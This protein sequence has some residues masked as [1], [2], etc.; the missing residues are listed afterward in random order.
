MRLTV[1]RDGGARRY[2]GGYYTNDA[3]IG[4]LNHLAA[5]FE[6]LDYIA[7]ITDMDDPSEVA[8][9]N[10]GKPVYL[11]QNINTY[12]T[13]QYWTVTNYY[14]HII[15][16]LRINWPVFRDRLKRGET[17]AVIMIIPSNNWLMVY[18]LARLRGIPIFPYFIGNQESIVRESGKYSGAVRSLAILLSKVHGFFFRLMARGADGVF[19]LGSELA[20]MFPAR[21][22]RSYQT[23]TSLVTEDDIQ[24]KEEFFRDGIVRV[25][26]AGR[27]SYEKNLYGLLD[28][29]KL[30]VEGGL[31]VRLTMAGN[32]PEEDG[33]R[34][35][36]SEL[37]ISDIVDL[38]G[39]VRPGKDLGRVYAEHDIF[40][41]SSLSE[42]VPKSIIEA[43]SKGL[44][45]VASRAGGMPDVVNDGVNGLL[46]EPGSARAIADAVSRLYNEPGLIA[47]LSAGG[48][49]YVREH[50]ADR[51]AAYIAE[52]VGAAAGEAL[53]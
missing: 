29:V 24:P 1:I 42:G 22:G 11:A 52:I 35:R 38:P 34:A 26:Y 19:H 28:A 44:G 14:R 33:L 46:A 36:A 7:P 2:R 30:M 6:S 16:V 9:F 17:D 39:F 43:M 21:P 49:E 10:V 47:K 8:V 4:F 41:M 13:Y 25:L 40:V 23:F 51:H 48:M 12:K 50:T 45:V 5:H 31:P 27:I 32:G 15:K 37:G 20:R 18:P 3:F 53:R